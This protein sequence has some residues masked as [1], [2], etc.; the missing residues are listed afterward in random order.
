V[1][2]FIVI[3]VLYPGVTRAEAEDVVVPHHLAHDAPEHA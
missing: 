1:L 3:K 2:A